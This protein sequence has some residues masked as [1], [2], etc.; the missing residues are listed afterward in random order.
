MNWKSTQSSEH[1][2]DRRPRS[3]RCPAART[4][5]RR[6][7]RRALPN[8]AGM[9]FEVRA[10]DPGRRAPSIRMKSPI[11]TITTAITD[12][13]CTGRMHDAAA[14][15]RRRRSAIAS[16]QE[17]R[18]PVREAPERELVGDVRRRH[19]HL[20]LREVDHLGRAVDEHERERE[21]A[22]DR[23][24]REA[25]DRLLREELADVSEPTS[26]KIA[27]RRASSTRTTHRCRGAGRRV[28]R[29]SSCARARRISS[30]GSSGGWTRALRAPRSARASATRP[31]SSTY[32]VC[33]S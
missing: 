29:I 7:G 10:P 16:V 25:R 22:V 28:S 3:C 21:A 24:L 15:R 13:C 19:R 27:R 31:T 32:A 33:A 30:P 17:E 6:R 12:R 1:R 20:A 11:V 23:A 5:R 26:R 14:W 2:D 4:R 8:G 9:N 18:E